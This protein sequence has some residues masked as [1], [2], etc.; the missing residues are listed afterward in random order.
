MPNESKQKL[1]ALFLI[2]LEKA[3]LNRSKLPGNIGPACGV[4]ANCKELLASAEAKKLL[5]R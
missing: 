2:R 1:G 5:K 4:C 3:C